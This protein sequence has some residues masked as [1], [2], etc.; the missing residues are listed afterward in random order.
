[1]ATFNLS[2]RPIKQIGGMKFR[3]RKKNST[4][5]KAINP[6]KKENIIQIQKKTKKETK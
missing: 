6:P 4:K 5:L 1:M 2:L 3:M